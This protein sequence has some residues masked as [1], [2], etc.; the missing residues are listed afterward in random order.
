VSIEEAQIPLLIVQA[1]EFVPMPNP[2]TVEEF[3]FGF[4][5]VPDPEINDHV[6]VPTEGILPFNTTEP[7]L[8]QTVWSN[9]ALEIVGMESTIIFTVSVEALQTPFEIVQT[10]EFVPRPKLLTE[11]ELEFGSAIVPDPEANVQIPIPVTGIFAVKFI[12]AVLP[13]IF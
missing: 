8:A 11:L 7:E 2:F 13:Q 1:N 9:P 4:A 5:T 6:P 3:K 12:V 10:K